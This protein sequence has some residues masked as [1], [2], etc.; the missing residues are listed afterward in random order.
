ML[1]RS[2]LGQDG[3]FQIIDKDGNVLATINKDTEADENGNVQIGY[4]GEKTE[5]N[6][7]FSKPLKLGNINILNTKEIKDTMKDA[8]VTKVETRNTVS[9]VNNVTEKTKV[10]D[11]ETKEE[12]EVENT[13]Q[14]EIYNYVGTSVAE[15][16]EAKTDVKVTANNTNWTNNVQNDV[17]FTATLVTSGPEYNLFKNPVIDIKL[18]NEVEKVVLGESSILYDSGLQLGSVQVVDDNGSKVIRVKVNGTQ[19]SYVQNEVV[20]GANIVIPASIILKK[21]I[22]SSQENIAV[23]FANY[24]N[25]KSP[26]TGNLD[27]PVNVTSIINNNASANEQNSNN[28]ASANGVATNFAAVSAQATLA[29]ANNTVVEAKPIDL[30]KISVEY[31][32]FLGDKELADGDSV[33]ENEYI[34]YV[35]KVRNNTGEDVNGLNVVASVPEGTTYVTVQNRTLTEEDIN[36]ADYDECK[37]T[38]F[39]E[40]KEFSSNVV[41]NRSEERRVGKECRS[42]WSP[43]H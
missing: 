19:T 39:P 12:K 30:D 26:E 31:K 24:R 9:C 8:N 6:F 22:V 21:D 10:I 33:H 28:G 16:K 18:P 37:I 43:Y 11:E 36:S 2:K 29:T 17:T 23:S 1:F 3:Y 40:Q 35:A 25:A 13:K 15:I 38:E 14:V 34:K 7:K 27:I 20:N 5:L 41:L 32:A 4:D 42:R